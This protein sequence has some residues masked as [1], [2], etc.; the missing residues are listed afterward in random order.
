MSQRM[1]YHWTPCDNGGGGGWIIALVAMLIILG[2]I[3][4]PAADA[5]H[6]V[7][8]V[9]TEVLEIAAITIASAAGAVAL[10]GIAWLV[11][12][13][14][15]RAAQQAMAAPYRVTVL[16]RAARRLAARAEA[17]AVQSPPVR[18][19]L[20]APKSQDLHLHLYGLTPDA[21]EALTGQLASGKN[22]HYISGQ[23]LPPRAID[24][25]SGRLASEYQV[26]EEKK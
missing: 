17:P 18:A 5:A 19:E 13:Q 6:A 14:R 7:A 15:R 2:A 9:V 3:A 20:D 12:R 1:G 11:V 24:P 10:G 21:I 26:I 25:A 16:R 8:R 22:G 4:K 23:L